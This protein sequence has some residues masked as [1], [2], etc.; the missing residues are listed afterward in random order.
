MLCICREN[1][2][3]GKEKSA[4]IIARDQGKTI[5]VS[6]VGSILKTLFKKGLTLPLGTAYTQEATLQNI[7]CQAM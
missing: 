4:V 6:T 1:P 7:P 3:W 5:S 2:T